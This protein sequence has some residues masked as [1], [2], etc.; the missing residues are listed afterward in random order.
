MDSSRCRAHGQNRWTQAKLHRESAMYRSN[1]HSCVRL[2]CSYPAYGGW[3]HV[4]WKHK[5]PDLEYVR[6]FPPL[7]TPR[8]KEGSS[9]RKFKVP[10]LPCDPRSVRL[11][12]HMCRAYQDTIR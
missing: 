2:S 7:A 10:R 3:K 11:A 4:G 12:R 1:R 5:S 6:S 8:P 9:L